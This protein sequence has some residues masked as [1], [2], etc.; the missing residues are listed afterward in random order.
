MKRS[1]FLGVCVIFLLLVSQ[2][3]SACCRVWQGS[4]V[5]DIGS[6][7][8]NRKDDAVMVY[9][10]EG[11]FL[12]GRDTPNNPTIRSVYLDAF[13][14]YQTEVTNDQFAKFASRT[15]YKTTAEV[16]TWSINY[17][18]PVISPDTYW[19]A[20]LGPGSDLSGMGDHPVVHVSWVDA[21]AYCRWA[22]GRLPTE[23]EWEKA[24]RGIDGQQYPWGDDPVTGDKANFCDLLCP[25]WVLRDESQNDGHGRTAPVGSYPAG[26]SPYGAL[27][28]AG[29]VKEW[30]ADWFESDYYLR[31]PNENPTGPDSGNT[32]VVRGGSW[33]NT[34][35]ALR[36]S[37]RRN[38]FEGASNDYIGFRCV[39]SP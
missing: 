26:I 33:M 10:P 17:L 7:K 19:A 30:V 4:A 14:I 8:V 31:S 21:D 1:G 6:T 24:A 11:E 32:R 12:M 23:A 29:N 22:G 15:R 25:D 39:Q 2:C 5:N 9:V 37:D 16:N 20:P 28:M 27:D 13:W 36:A 34:E 38:E 3:L 18:S 35:L